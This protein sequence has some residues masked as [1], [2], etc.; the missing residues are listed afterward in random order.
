M[1]DLPVNVNATR[2]L[3]RTRKF[4]Q[5]TLEADEKEHSLEMQLPFLK[6][7]TGK[8]PYVEILPIMVGQLEPH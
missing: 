6:Y 4:K 7:L 2:E 3:L 5:M 8:K 1:G